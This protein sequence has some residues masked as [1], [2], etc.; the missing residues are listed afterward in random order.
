M[1]VVYGQVVIL[2]EKRNISETE[3][4]ITNVATDH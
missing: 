3:Q 1:G 4:D 2:A